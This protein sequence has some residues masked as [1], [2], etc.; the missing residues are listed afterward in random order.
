MSEARFDRIDQRLDRTDGRLDGIDQRLDRIDGRL[1]GLEAGQS[2]LKAGQQELKA[3]YSELKAGQQEL[4]AGYSELKAGQ[5]EL[6]A[7][8]VR[9]RTDLTNQMGTMYERLVD[10]IRA[11]AIPVPELE[12]RWK[13]DDALVLESVG[14]RIDPLETAVK[15]HFGA[16]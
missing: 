8:L 1:D 5:D 14:R 10:D 15:R 16:Q 9:L 4:K 3:G 7:E 12:R 11:L 6:K 2:E 13:A